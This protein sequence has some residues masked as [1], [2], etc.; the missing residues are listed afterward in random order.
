MWS[1]EENLQHTETFSP[2]TSVAPINLTQFATF[3]S[4]KVIATVIAKNADGVSQ[5]AS[6]LLPLRLTGMWKW[7]GECVWKGLA[8][9][10]QVIRQK[11]IGF[12]YS[13]RHKFRDMFSHVYRY[14]GQLG[15]GFI[16]FQ[17]S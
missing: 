16:W 13:Q 9:K 12:I 17:Q 3:S 7:R 2:D 1:P 15:D 10:K 6:V 14:V 11:V 5:P 4:D 8:N